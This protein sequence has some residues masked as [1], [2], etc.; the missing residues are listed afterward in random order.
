MIWTQQNRAAPIPPYAVPSLHE[1]VLAYEAATGG[2][3]VPPHTFGLDVLAH[4]PAKTLEREQ[5]M[6]HNFNLEDIFSRAVNGDGT[7]L[8]QAVTYH[9]RLTESLL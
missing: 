9:R 5:K 8:Q 4:S 1:A 3:L 6:R 7:L 2:T